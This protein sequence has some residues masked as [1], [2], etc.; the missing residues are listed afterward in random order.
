MYLVHYQML[1]CAYRQSLPSRI[2]FTTAF[3]LVVNKV[4]PRY[5]FQ[6]QFTRTSGILTIFLAS[7]LRRGKCD[8]SGTW[9]SWPTGGLA[10]TTVHSPPHI[11]V[12]RYITPCMSAQA[13]VSPL[14]KPGQHLYLVLIIHCLSFSFSFVPLCT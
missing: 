3:I 4:V 10:S 13:L 2:A 14:Y 11:F 7:V 1:H 8:A 5:S 9:A 6:V 12:P